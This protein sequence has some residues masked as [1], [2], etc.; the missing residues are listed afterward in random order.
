MPID[1]P[2]AGCNARTVHQHYNNLQF[3]N[4]HPAN[5]IRYRGYANS[6]RVTSSQS[7]VANGGQA[8][9][10]E[11]TLGPDILDDKGSAPEQVV[12]EQA[13]VTGNNEKDDKEGPKERRTLIIS[14][15]VAAPEE[16]SDAQRSVAPVDHPQEQQDIVILNGVAPE[17]HT[18]MDEEISHPSPR[19]PI[20]SR[21]TLD[22]VE[23]LINP[24]QAHSL[25]IDYDTIANAL[26]SRGMQELPEEPPSTTSQGLQSLFD[27]WL[28][29]NTP[30]Q[31]SET[32]SGDTQTL[33]DPL[34]RLSWEDGDDEL[35]SSVMRPS[36]TLYMQQYF[37]AIY[38]HSSPLSIMA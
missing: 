17:E 22:F 14:L 7:D 20:T 31:A 34:H 5:E 18:M 1:C 28:V 26:A 23:D 11:E 37:A 16:R 27:E 15:R 19:D 29:P 4:P 8:R 30:E 2:L 6:H 32:L 10:G 33:A 38:G 24:L 9:Q 3:F 21:R 36:P 13:S 35:P 25:E 12:I